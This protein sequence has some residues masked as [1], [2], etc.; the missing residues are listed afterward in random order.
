M[1]YISVQYFSAQTDSDGDGVGDE[2]DN[3]PQTSNH[4]QTD[5]NYSGVG[6]SCDGQDK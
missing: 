1:L 6:D 2:C 4:A 5:S 3:C